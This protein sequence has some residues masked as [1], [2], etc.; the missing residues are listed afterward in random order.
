MTAK[1][2]EKLFPSEFAAD[3]R[4]IHKSEF[5]LPSFSSVRKWADELKYVYE[6]DASEDLPRKYLKKL[7]RG[8][9]AW[10]KHCNAE[11]ARELRKLPEN[12]PVKCPFSLFGT[13]DYGRLEVAHTRTLAWLLDPQKE[14]GFG[15]VLLS[16]LLRNCCKRQKLPRVKK[17]EAERLYKQVDGEDTGRTD[18]WIEGFWENQPWVLVIEAKI[19][20]SESDHQLD[21]YN[22][23][24]RAEREKQI[25]CLFLTPDGREAESGEQKWNALSFSAL[26]RVFCEAT[27]KLATKPG[28]HFLRF[29]LAGILKDVLGLPVGDASRDYNQYKLLR[30]LK[31]S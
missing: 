12:H 16:A 15:T 24:I 4:S 29:Y 17:V 25:D 20:S 23:E 14:H 1:K 7:D 30:F 6:M 2:K 3:L 27:D 10:S 5:S 22:K 31:G 11:L 19:D 18:I 28:Y 21:R 9:K 8:L 26:A 13:M